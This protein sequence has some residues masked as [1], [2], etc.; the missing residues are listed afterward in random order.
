MRLQLTAPPNAEEEP[1]ELYEGAESQQQQPEGQAKYHQQIQGLVMH[2]QVQQHAEEH[3]AAATAANAVAAAPVVCPVTVEAGS[4]AAHEVRQNIY[5]SQDPALHNS[6]TVLSA[7][8]AAGAD[9]GVAEEGVSAGVS[10]SYSG[11][12]R[13]R[14]PAAL[15]TGSQAQQQQ[16]SGLQEV[17]VAIAD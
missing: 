1:P 3:N 17:Q 2:Q 14:T 12:T 10:R 9:A 7:R 13:H 16:V 11:G 8:G 4:A 5:S 6:A 15:R